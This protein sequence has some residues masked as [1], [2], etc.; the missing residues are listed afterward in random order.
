MGY[1]I[2]IPNRIPEPPP[3]PV[4][5]PV[6]SGFQRLRQWLARHLR[7][8][9]RRTVRTDHEQEF[10]TGVDRTLPPL[11]RCEARQLDHD[12]IQRSL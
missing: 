2:E 8:A 4:S 3:V 6:P 7:R 9:P 1:P 10:G 11:E 5:H 12:R